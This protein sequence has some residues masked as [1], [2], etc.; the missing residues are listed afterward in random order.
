MNNPTFSETIFDVFVPA[1]SDSHGIDPASA[2][3]AGQSQ[4]GDDKRKVY[5]ESNRHRACN[6][7]TFE[8]RCLHAAGRAATRYPTIAFAVLPL[9]SLRHV[10]TYDLTTNRLTAVTDLAALQAWIGDLPL[11]TDLR[12]VA[13]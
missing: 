6:I 11:A 2:I 1:S 4:H 12:M 5:F 7:T 10:G 8:D 13:L 3:V 9:A